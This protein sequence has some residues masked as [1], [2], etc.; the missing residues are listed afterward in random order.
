[1]PD[2]LKV[3]VIKGEVLGIKTY[4][5][6]AKL[7][8]IS[9]I[10]SADIFDQKKN[11]TGTQRDLNVQHAKD[12]YKYV[13]SSE[14]AFWPEVV[15]CCREESIIEFTGTD[16]ETGA[17]LLEI[18]VGYIEE[19]RSNGKIAIS[20]LDGNHRL[21]FAAGDNKDMDPIQRQASFCLLIGISLEDEI[22]I[23][24]DINNNQRRMN[25][26]H[27]DTIVIKLTPEQRLMVENRELYLAK[28][29]ADDPE[30]PLHGR[31]YEGG[32]KS[33]GLHIPLRT[34]NT[35]IK[36]M[37][38]RST[39]IDQ[40]EDVEAK[41]LFI[42]NYW[43][44]LREWIPGAWAEPKKYLLLR[45]AGLW[46]ACVLGGIVIDRCLEKGQYSIQE[47]L[48]VLKS[49]SDWDWSRSGNFKGYSG[50]GGA[51]EI[52]NMISREF[53]TES[54]VSIKKLASKI[55]SS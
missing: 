14:L 2:T 44:A 11:P 48:N 4:R 20:R 6:L 23:F 32:K 15:L 5:G 38:Q 54:G 26:S 45:G 21:H 36:Y 47:I 19:F 9:R 29:L 39:K 22:N 49:G 25:T 18:K 55:K 42:R 7:S 28:K 24:R 41:Y 37:M 34:L 40:L 10:S 12:A 51:V 33:P 3:P 50:R 46:G 52:A 43:K 53:A 27:L 13:A 16:E 17:G 35:G 8:D 30:S 31:V 1:M